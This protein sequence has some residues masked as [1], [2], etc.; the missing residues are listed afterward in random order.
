M[1]KSPF[2]SELR[3][4]CRTRHLSRRTEDAY[5]YWT[6]RFVQYHH[7]RKPS[8]ME[9]DH[10]TQ[11]LSHLAEKRRV[12]A[13]T[14]NQALSALL[15]VY[16]HI[17]GMDLPYIEGFKTP[18]IKTRLPVVLTRAEVARVLEKL[19][20]QN[21]LVAELLYGA[22]LRLSE[23]LGL[24]MKDL[25]FEYRQLHLHNTKGRNQRISLMPHQ[26]IPRIENQ[27]KQVRLLYESDQQPPE[28]RITLPNALD[29]K[30][31]NA[32]H[33]WRWMYLFPARQLTE[34]DTGTLYRHHVYP[35]T[36]QKAVHEAI[37]RSGITKKASCH[38]L[39]HSFA[40]HLLE[41]GTDIRT[42]QELLGHKDVRTTMIYTHVLK[43][44]Q[45][46]IRSPLDTGLVV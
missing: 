10:I 42:V 12:A 40:T 36:I 7:F 31:V 9:V 33:D 3:R 19:H 23:C 30:Y 6:I 4:V 5:L 29:R 11:F 38:T 34:T 8:E 41:N 21:R 44:S 25:D 17:L 14:Q 18:R 22:G 16:R 1:S 24:R 28:V 35:T 20:G 15:F 43:I 26:S 2:L 13:S 32:P 45:H 37:I 46:G 27:I 39:R